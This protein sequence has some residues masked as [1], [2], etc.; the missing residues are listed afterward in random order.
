MIEIIAIAAAGVML[1]RAVYT[2]IKTGKIENRLVAAGLIAGLLF[3]AVRDG[4]KGIWTS[5]RMMGIVF[6]MLIFLFIIKGLGAGDIKLFCVLAVFFPEDII[7]I[8]IVSFF[9]GGIAATGKILLRLFRG[10]SLYIRHE[11][12]NFSVPIFVGTALVVGIGWICS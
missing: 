10:K 5:V 12:M 4:P 7:Q 8:I 1:C 9:A 6:V 11:T 3:A 2:D